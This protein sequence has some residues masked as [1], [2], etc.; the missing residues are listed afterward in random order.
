MQIDQ[1]KLFQQI[2]NETEIDMNEIKYEIKYDK[3]I[4][5]AEHK[6]KAIKALIV[7]D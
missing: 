5:K 6:L 2:L 4:K 1:E 7:V 3:N